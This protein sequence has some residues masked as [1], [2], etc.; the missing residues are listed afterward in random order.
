VC[1]AQDFLAPSDRVS[2]SF[3]MFF[4][5]W[6]IEMVERVLV[7]HGVLVIPEDLVPGEGPAEP[8]EPEQY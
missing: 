6:C 8:A 5:D 7:A 1:A 4:L 3:P 2:K